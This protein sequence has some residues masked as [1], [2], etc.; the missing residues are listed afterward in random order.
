[1]FVLNDPR[2]C[3][4][5]SVICILAT[6]AKGIARPSRKLQEK[7]TKMTMH[8]LVIPKRILKELNFLLF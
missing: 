4:T 3:C 1:M 5:V 8:L 7:V 2:R 6:K